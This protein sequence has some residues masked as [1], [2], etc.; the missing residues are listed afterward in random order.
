VKDSNVGTRLNLM[1]LAGLIGARVTVPREGV[2][3][4][5]VTRQEARKLG[6]LTSATVLNLWV[7]PKSGQLSRIAVPRAPASQQ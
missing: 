4:S 1:S 7:F 5:K 2:R 6:S 3:L